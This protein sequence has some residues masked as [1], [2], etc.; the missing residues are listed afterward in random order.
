MELQPALEPIVISPLQVTWK[1]ATFTC[2]GDGLLKDGHKYDTQVEKNFPLLE[3]A[4]TK[5]G[6]IA[7]RQP[8]IQK[9][10]A[11]YWKAQ[12]AFRNLTQSGRISDLQERLRH[13]DAAMNEELAKLEKQLNAQFRTKNVAARNDKWKGFKTDEAK[14]NADP[15]RFLR[16]RFPKSNSQQS[17]GLGGGV[18]V[19]KTHG[20]LQLH[21][22]AEPLGLCHES[23]NAPLNSEGERPA[24]D[25]W[26]VIGRDRAAVVEKIREISREAARSRQRAQEAKDEK[27]RKLHEKGVKSAEGGSWDVTGSWEIKCPYMEDNWGEETDACSLDIYLSSSSNGTR[28]LW[29]EFDFIAITG[30]FRFENPDRKSTEP[31][32]IPTNAGRKPTIMAAPSDSDDDEEEDFDEDSSSRSTPTPLA[33]YLPPTANPSPGQPQWSYRWRGEE[34]GEGEIQLYSDEELC[35]VTFHGAGGSELTGVFESGLTGRIEFTGVRVGGVRAPSVVDVEEAWS[36]RAYE[37]A[38]VGRWG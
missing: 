17:T 31:K 19:L 18:V 15:K 8:Q 10:P 33:F 16:E 21:L 11:A 30:V 23:V 9:Q 13:A 27:T 12:C 22:E 35:S 7:A 2:S 37:S 6:K 3:P 26:I 36:R 5:A 28:Q 34:T 38:R 1:S 20:R 24:V 14:A 25:R 4:R 32:P 29:A